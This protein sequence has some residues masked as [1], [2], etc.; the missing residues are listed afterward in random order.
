MRRNTIGVRHLL[1]GG[2]QILE[3]EPI[4]YASRTHIL[5]AIHR[6]LEQVEKGATFAHDRACVVPPSEKSS[7][8]SYSFLDRYFPDTAD[9][10]T[11]I[12]IVRESIECL[13]RNQTVVSEKASLTHEFLK[14]LLSSLRAE[15]LLLA[16][17]PK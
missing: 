9:L 5:A 2:I 7:F 6:F 11:T 12:P 3:G 15:R 1:E 16:E 10:G 14:K 4:D 17:N 8:A 13:Q